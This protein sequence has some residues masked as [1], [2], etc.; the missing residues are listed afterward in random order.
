MYLNK[1]VTIE[2]YGI[3]RNS[4]KSLCRAFDV[5]YDR[6]I[7]IV[8]IY[9]DAIILYFVAAGSIVAYG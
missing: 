8:L 4:K 3:K 1:C 2:K 7:F 5:Y 6:N 9:S